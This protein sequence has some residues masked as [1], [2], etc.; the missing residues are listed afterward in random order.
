MKI[1]DTFK[2]KHE[3]FDTYYLAKDIKGLH[4]LASYKIIE[5]EHLS[6]GS[7]C[8]GPTIIES[9][10]GQVFNINDMPE[11]SRIWCFFTKE[12]DHFYEIIQ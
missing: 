3:W 4:T 8:V 2:F 11:L 9:E 10:Y 5:L 12:Q 7:L 1:G 6:E